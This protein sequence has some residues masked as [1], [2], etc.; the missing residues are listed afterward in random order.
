MTNNYSPYFCIY[1]AWHPKSSDAKQLGE[2]IFKYICGDPESA[3]VNDVYIP[4][5]LCL[6]ITLSLNSFILTN[7]LSRNQNLLKV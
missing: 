4:I 1:L 3:L 2:Y 6:P 5:L 7:H